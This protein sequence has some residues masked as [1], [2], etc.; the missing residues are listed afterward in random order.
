MARHLTYG[1]ARPTAKGFSSFA[2][3]AF[4]ALLGVAFW[5]GV[6]WIGQA[7]LRITGLGF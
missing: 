2:C 1:A 5:A 3:F 6:I 4:V 7:V